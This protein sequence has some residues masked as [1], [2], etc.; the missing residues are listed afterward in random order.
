[1][2]PMGG[3]KGI[4]RNYVQ[5]VGTLPTYACVWPLNSHK[6][7]LGE[8]VLPQTSTSYNTAQLTEDMSSERMLERGQRTLSVSLQRRATS[9]RWNCSPKLILRRVTTTRH[10]IVCLGAIHGRLLDKHNDHCLAECQ[11]QAVSAHPPV[12]LIKTVS[13]QSR[14]TSMSLAVMSAAISSA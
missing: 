10:R 1:M 4:M 12:N 5:I 6:P 3:W 11:W 13:S 8:G 2:D 14:A 7:I 9:L